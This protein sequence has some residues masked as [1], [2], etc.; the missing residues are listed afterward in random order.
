MSAQAPNG[1]L[2][3][4]KRLV[5]EFIVI[6]LGVLVALSV[7]AG[8]EVRAEGR[9]EQAYYQ[10]LAR[11]ID[12]D[13]AEYAT[14]IRMTA[15]SIEA[16]RHVMAAISGDPYPAKRPLSQSVS[17]ASWVN[18]PDWSSGTL[19]ELFSVGAIR[20]IRNQEIKDAIHDYRS[21]VNEWRPRMQGPEYGAFLDYRRVIAGLI[22]LEAQT[23]YVRTSLADE[24]VVGVEVDE[25]LLAERLRGNQPLLRELKIMMVQWADLTV[26]YQQQ[27]EFALRLLNLLQVNDNR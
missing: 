9:R 12:D 14:A 6:V 1:T 17:Y 11:D 10:S 3:L 7:D 23:A 13:T 4:G 15:R 27:R 16:G 19:D 8:L 25:T 2:S 24:R 18:Y 26:L 20:L 5:G 22:P 21:D